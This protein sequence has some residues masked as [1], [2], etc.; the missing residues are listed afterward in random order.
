[1][2]AEGNQHSKVAAFFSV[3]SGSEP[4]GSN[5]VNVSMLTMNILFI[6]CE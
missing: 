4:E 6:G 3:D 1:M 5:S 2:N